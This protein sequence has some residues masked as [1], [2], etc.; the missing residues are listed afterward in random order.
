M[1]SPSPF[2]TVG[3]TTISLSQLPAIKT[4]SRATW[5]LG[6]PS[7]L[8]QGSCYRKPGRDEGNILW[9]MLPSLDQT[10]AECNTPPPPTWCHNP[11]SVIT[12]HWAKWQSFGSLKQKTLPLPTHIAL[13]V[14]VLPLLHGCNWL[15]STG[16]TMSTL[17]HLDCKQQD[18]RISEV[19]PTNV[20]DNEKCWINPG[21]GAP[22][23]F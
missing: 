18:E 22:F 15:F 2:S 5:T 14:C 23:L 10:K 8:H 9:L 17:N 6:M 1:L 19:Q 3:P 16:K 20:Q 4:E 12:L 13:P 11:L 7:S 21:H